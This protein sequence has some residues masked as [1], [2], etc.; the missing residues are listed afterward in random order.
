MNQKI[1]IT[2]AGGFIAHHMVNYLK[3]KGLWVLEQKY[4]IG[5]KGK[6]PEE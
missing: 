4:N 6:T 5:K 3:D 1:L 2:G